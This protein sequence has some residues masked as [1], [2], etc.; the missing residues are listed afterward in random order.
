MGLGDVRRKCEQPVAGRKRGR[1]GPV[2]GEAVGEHHQH[3]GIAVV[4]RGRP[5]GAFAGF[6]DA[7][8]LR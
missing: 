4:D 3:A 2:R 7:A 1:I 5:L 6:G 8:L